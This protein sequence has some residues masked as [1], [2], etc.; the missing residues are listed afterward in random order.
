[1]TRVAIEVR[2]LSYSYP[3]GRPALKGVSLVVEEGEKVGLVGRNGAGKST[4]L[5]HLNGILRGQGEVRIMG[6]PLTEANLRLIR[7]QVGLVFQD[8]DDQLFCATVLDDVAFGPLNMG[9][10][11]EEV[12]RRSMMALEQVGMAEHA[13]RLPHHLSLGEKKRVAIATVLS[14]GPPILALDEPLAGLDPGGQQALLELLQS[15]PQT[16]VVATHDLAL[17]RSLCQRVIILEQGR[18]MAEGPPDLEAMRAWL[19]GVTLPTAVAGQAT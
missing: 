8:P 2:D 4:W 7:S 1:M 3:D 10:S 15:L 13:A 17:V 19:D 9:L 12:L 11:Q 16:V 6:A 5:M 18:V 14:M